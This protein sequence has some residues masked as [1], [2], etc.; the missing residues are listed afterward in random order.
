MKLLIFDMD[1]VLVDPTYSY[2]ATTIETIVHFSGR[3][4]T[5]EEIVIMK[6]RGGY[7]DDCVLAFDML[8]ELGVE[9]DY[10]QLRLQFHKLFWGTAEDG[11]VCQESWLVADGVLG[12]LGVINRLAIYTGRPTCAARFALGRFATDVRFDPVVTSDLIENQ[13]P[14]PDGLLRVLAS[15]PGCEATYVGDNIDDARC[16]RAA[17]VSFVGVAARNSYRRDEIVQLFQDEGAQVV[18]ESVNELES[19]L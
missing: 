7:N 1:G 11:L 16:A 8:R 13:K 17:G 4:I 6:N 3:R 10:E 5:Q 9:V 15:V 18:V 2:R 14:A 12:R 19:A